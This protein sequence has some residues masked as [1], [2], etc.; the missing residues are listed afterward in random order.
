M[1]LAIRSRSD[2]SSAEAI[3]AAL[4]PQCKSRLRDPR[5]S[6]A[7]MQRDRGEDEA[8]IR[9]CGALARGIVTRRACAA[10]AA[11]AGRSRLHNRV[12]HEP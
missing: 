12:P 9:G 5:R 6:K 8:A 1:R 4:R 2:L 7:G 10:A 3:L 11:M